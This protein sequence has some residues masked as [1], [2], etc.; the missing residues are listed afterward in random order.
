[1]VALLQASSA[2]TALVGS[3]IRPLADPTQIPLPYITYRRVQTRRDAEMGGNSNDGASGAALARIQLDAWAI[4]L[5]TAKQLATLIRQTLNGYHGTASGI[6][7]GS[8]HISDET[9]VPNPL[10]PGQEKPVQHIAVTA[11]ILFAE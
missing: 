11:S 1:M 8:I 3:N 4:D 6:V 10:W 7:I 2:I 9:E 5:L